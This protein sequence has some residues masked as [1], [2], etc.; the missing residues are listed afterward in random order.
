MTLFPRVLSPGMVGGVMRAAAQ[1]SLVRMMGVLMAGVGI[2]LVLGLGSMDGTT[3]QGQVLIGGPDNNWLHGGPGIDMAVFSGSRWAYVIFR[4]GDQVV[5]VGP[6]GEDRLSNVEVLHFDDETV[7][8]AAALSRTLS[9][10][11]LENI[12]LWR[13]AR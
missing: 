10:G 13:I 1:K 7:N 11:V 4:N 3:R 8:L 2:A 12:P 6:D 9:N 5:V